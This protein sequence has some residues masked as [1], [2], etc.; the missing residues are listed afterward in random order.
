MFPEVHNVSYAIFIGD[1]VIMARHVEEVQVDHCRVII[2][3]ASG[4]NITLN[5]KSHEEA[6]AVSNQITSELGCQ[7]GI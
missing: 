1:R 6:K 5:Y 4:R 2:Y 7:R 3:M